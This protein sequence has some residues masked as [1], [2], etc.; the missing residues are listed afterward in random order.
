MLRKA[1]H[2][3]SNILVFLR[4]INV[5]RL[6][7]IKEAEILN[8]GGLNVLI[9][10]NNAGKSNLLT[11]IVGFFGVFST[12]DIVSLNPIFRDEADY[13]DRDT[14]KPIEITCCFSITPSQSTDIV[15]L[16][17]KNYPPVRNVVAGLA[18]SRYLKATVKYFY[19]PSPFGLVTTLAL[20]STSD[21]PTHQAD[22]LVY[23]VADDVAP[24]LEERYRQASKK[25]DDNADFRRALQ[26]IDRDVYNRARRETLS[27]RRPSA[28]V[29]FRN[30]VD[31]YWPGRLREEIGA[32]LDQ[33]FAQTENYEEF[34][35]T[36]GQRVTS[37]EAEVNSIQ[38]APVAGAILT[39]GG[40]EHVVPSYVSALCKCF[41]DEKVLYQR[42]G[43]EPISPLDAQRLLSA[44]VQKGGDRLFR[45]F[46]QTVNALIGVEIDAFEDSTDVSD[47]RG[48]LGPRMQSERI[49]KLD[50][51]NFLIQVNGSGIK[52]ALRLL[53]DVELVKPTIM[54]IEEPE[55]H[56]HPGLETSIRRYLK[57]RSE[58]SQI[59]LTTHSTNFIDSGEYSSIYF[60]KKNAY[61]AAS[62][63][64]S[65]EAAEV[66]PQEL[67]LR[68]STLFMFD[69]LLFVE[70]ASDEEVLREWAAISSKNLTQ[71]GVGFINLGGSRNIKHFAARQTTDFLSK[72][73]VDLWFVLDRDEKRDE[74]V[75]KL[76]RALGSR[77]KVKI[78]PVREIEN[79]LVNP[80]PLCRYISSRLAKGDGSG[81]T[82]KITADEVAEAVNQCVEQL[83]DFTLGKEL[84]SRVN[85]PVY[86]SAELRT[87]DTLDK[88]VLSISEALAAGGATLEQRA[89]SIEGTLQE[90]REEFDRTWERKKLVLVPGTELLDAV[91][92]RYGLAY[93]KMR[94]AK[95]IASI[96]TASEIPSVIASL[97]DEVVP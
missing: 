19:K 7:S 12:G 90:I 32:A 36:L 69:K 33:D 17:S 38:E 93:R 30:T 25:K 24:Q 23:Q 42:E 76:E 22:A 82:Q 62:L 65:E 10:K 83:R 81:A 47:L 51:D 3:E 86:L 88:M 43:R 74:E 46:Q 79:Y 97:L 13:F 5:V 68:L 94:D 44:R 95:A 53:L 57:R 16:I 26:V 59:F 11:A 45:A 8:C 50:V 27:E 89:G 71:A 64:T 31:I 70:G 61:T 66:L 56:L 58:V 2:Q 73:G 9:G 87:T 14:S 20:N 91:L 84:M 77:C 28:A 34:R 35:A 1:C 40:Q 85:A 96:M 80:E 15:S 41:S 21:L 78:L 6:R 4:N 29:P 48:R 60:V 55:I 75:A 49:A 72:R 37:G 52:E 63:L 54:L 18:E 67:G 92:K 39:V